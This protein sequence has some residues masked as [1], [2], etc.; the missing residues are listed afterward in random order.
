[1]NNLLKKYFQY[2][3]FKD[4]QLNVIESILRNENNLVIKSTGKGKSLCY[5][6]LLS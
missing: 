5:Q 3:S 6:F 4:Y 1:M 2:N